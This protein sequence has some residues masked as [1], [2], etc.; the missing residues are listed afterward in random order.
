MKQRI[1]TAIGIILVVALPVALGGL[2][3]EALA[4]FIVCASAYE[5]MHIQPDFKKWPKYVMPLCALAVI[6]TRI[7]PDKYFLVV[8]T[9]IVLFLWSL[10]VFVENFSIMDSFVCISYVTIFSLVYHAVGQISGVHQYLWT[11]VFATYGSDTGAYFVGRAIGKH[12]MNPRISPKKS[13]E[14]F[15]GGIVF[16]FILSLAVSF[17]YVSNLN[18]VLNTLLRLLCPITAELGDLCFS[19]IKRHFAVKD[20]SNLLPGHGGVLDRVDSLLMNIMLFSVLYTIILEGGFR[21]ILLLD[22]S[23]LLS[24]E[25]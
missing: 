12:K 6:F 2:W 4:L 3:L 1:I 9:L 21:W 13:W 22:C 10:V 17:S 20:F 15:V 14:G 25:V 5:W 11:I 19:A 8:V 23:Q 7:L 24:C 18:S 16:G